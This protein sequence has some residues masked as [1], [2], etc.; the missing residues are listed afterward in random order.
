MAVGLA[1]GSMAA[2]TAATVSLF[3]VDLSVAGVVD[4][5]FAIGGGAAAVSLGASVVASNRAEDRRGLPGERWLK[6]WKGRVG[7]WL[8]KVA[9]FGLKR[10]ASADAAHRPTEVAIGMAADRLYEELPR[11]VRKSFS[12]LPDIVRTLEGD[13]EQMRARVNELNGILNDIENDEMVGQR[14]TA[15]AAPGVADKRASLKGDL[16]KTRDAAETRL[17]EL[18]ASLETIRL[19]LLRMHA[20]S[21]SVESMT[22]DLT[23]A[24]ELS[25]EVQLLLDGRREVDAL[26]AV[27]EPGG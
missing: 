22:A 16:K 17:A 11:E 12:E 20:G 23:S 15:A 8:F 21:G 14:R 27:E 1:Y 2:C 5:I 10:V 18:L 25:D 24:R 3:M 4:T 26:L 9:G 13:A 6:F 7:R 19:D